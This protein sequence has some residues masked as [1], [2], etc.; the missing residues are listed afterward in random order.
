MTTE[1]H[2]ATS[3][4]SEARR[5]WEL[6]VDA[7]EQRYCSI[8]ADDMAKPTPC[9]EWGVSALVEHA[10]DAHARYGV[11]LGY[12]MGDARDWSTVGTRMA[13][14]LDN[15]GELASGTIQHTA[16]GETSKLYMLGII[17]NDLL[18][19]TWDLARAIG[20][21]ETLAGDAV[22][23]SLVVVEQAP[24][25]VVR[26]P[27]VWGDDLPVA[28]NADPQTRLLAAVG[29]NPGGSGQSVNTAERNPK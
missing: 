29:R 17:T 6:T 28:A 10:I 15:D 18:V 27:K 22:A 1:T 16:L 13:T 25:N 2:S 14:G 3:H 9:A 26:H 20:A 7:W 8:Q 19:H 11:M 24:T 4:A 5:V 23:A 21:D 12:E